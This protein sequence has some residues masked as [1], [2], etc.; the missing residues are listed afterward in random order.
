M[1]LEDE[2]WPLG[3]KAASLSHGEG[4]ILNLDDNLYTIWLENQ[5]GVRFVV[6]ERGADYEPPP[7]G[8]VYAHSELPIQV[9]HDIRQTVV[10]TEVEAC[11]HPPGSIRPT[12]GWVDGVEGRKCIECGGSQTRNEDKPWPKTWGYGGSY[13]LMTGSSGYAQNLVLAMTRPTH[14]EIDLSIARAMRE[15]YAPV[16]PRARSEGT[17][18]FVG[19][20]YAEVTGAQ[21]GDPLVVTG[22]GPKLYPLH[23]AILIAARACEGC[24][25]VLLWEY[26]CDDGYEHGSEEHERAGTSCLFCTPVET[27]RAKEIESVEA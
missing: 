26:G 8:F 20:Q 1:T 18:G 3:Q 9:H 6:P 5:E 13:P 23:D 7:E 24:M 25:N 15:G 21:A 12:G 22:P 4:W 2:S 14:K 10:K 27:V 17:I 11:K 16:A 19:P